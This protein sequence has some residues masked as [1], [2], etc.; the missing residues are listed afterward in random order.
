MGRV[1]SNQSDANTHQHLGLRNFRLLKVVKSKNITLPV[2][3]PS[4]PRCHQSLDCTRLVR[5]R[6]THAGSVGIY[7][8]SVLWTCHH[9]GLWSIRCVLKALRQVVMNLKTMFATSCQ[10]RSCMILYDLVWSCFQET[11]ATAAC[12]SSLGQ[13]GSRSVHDR[14]PTP[15]A[16]AREFQEVSLGFV[17]VELR[18]L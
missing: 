17:E 3:T 11:V 6:K 2:G 9:A 13:V 1:N 4:C 14:L 15:Y 10:I 7:C 5:R 12:T 16:S 18:R 8:V